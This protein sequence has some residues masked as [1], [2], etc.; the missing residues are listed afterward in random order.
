MQLTTWAVSPF[1]GMGAYE[2]LWLRPRTT[3]RSP[4]ARFAARPGSV[5]SHFLPVDEATVNAAYVKARFAQGG[6]GR[7]GVRVRG[8]GEFPPQLSE[9]AHPVALLH[10][11]GRWALASSHSVAAVGTRRASARGVAPT[12]SL[13]R[14]LVSDGWTVVSGLAVGIDRAAHE[15]AM[16]A[17]GRTVAVIGTPLSHAYPRANADLQRQP[18]VDFLVVSQVPLRRYEAQDGRLNRRFFPAR[19]VTMAAL[20]AATVFVEAAGHRRAR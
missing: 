11:Q 6:V 7:F 19:N 5:P 17:G 8:A 2:A 13:V 4:A 12:R 14:H 9:A 20:T 18:A 1:R 3:F 10:F 15:A 16:R